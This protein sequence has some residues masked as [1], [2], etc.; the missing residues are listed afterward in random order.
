VKRTE[1]EC[2][3]AKKEEHCYFYALDCLLHDEVASFLVAGL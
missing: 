2:N 1:S 3:G